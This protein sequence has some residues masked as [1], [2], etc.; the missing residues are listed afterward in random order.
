MAETRR[1][2]DHGFRA[3]ALWLGRETGKPRRRW[4]GIC[5]S[6]RAPR[7]TG[8]TPTSGARAMGPARS[9][10][11]SGRN[12]TG[13][14]RENAELAM[15]CDVLKPSLVPGEGR[16]EAVA[17][18]ALMAAQGKIT[19]SPARWPPGKAAS[20]HPFCV[21]GSHLTHTVLSPSVTQTG[22]I[23]QEARKKGA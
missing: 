5:E 1:K 4:R 8:R 7:A 3:G 23:S 9:M 17:V 16:D 18:A 19:R 22:G 2:F 12:W 11:V 20:A 15:E 14:R 13:C 10:R 21:N 6:T